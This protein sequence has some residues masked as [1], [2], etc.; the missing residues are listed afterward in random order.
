MVKNGTVLV[1][2]DDRDLGELIVD[3]LRRAGFEAFHAEDGR[4]GLRQVWQLRPDLVTVDLLMP[5]LDGWELVRRIREVS[6]V[7]I[8]VVSIRWDI[9]ERLKG[10]DLGIDDFVGKP[11]S[12]PEL[13]AR[14]KARLRKIAEPSP[15]PCV[16]GPL[17]ID[18]QTQALKK[19][20]Q[21]LHLTPL[22]FRLLRYLI[23][24]RGKA[25]TRRQILANV[26]QSYDENLLPSVKVYIHL[27][28]KKIEDSP[29]APKLL[30]TAPHR[31]GYVLAV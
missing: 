8:I 11:F 27:L 22:E 29:T 31:Q 13:V 4:D 17:V 2:E 3:Y 21:S 18:L 15:A 16:V 6:D 24:N 28:R 23:E 12:V 1:V 7:P 14:V 19:N 10:F 5:H 9:D 25:M 20:E 30:V 26:W